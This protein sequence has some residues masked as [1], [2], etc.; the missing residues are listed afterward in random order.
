MAIASRSGEC[1]QLFDQWLSSRFEDEMLR[2]DIENQV[3]RFNLWASNHAIFAP[4]KASMDWR[5]RSAPLLES[6]MVEML[7]DLHATLIKQLALQHH[8]TELQDGTIV[9]ALGEALD[10]LF[11]L[12]RAIRRSGIMRRFVKV[13]N[14]VEY[15]EEG[16]NLTAAFREGTERIIAFR[17]RTSRASPELRQR[18]VDTI[19]LRQQHF[20]YLRAKSSRNGPVRRNG[21]P[22]IS[23]GKS[24]LSATF[25]VTGS[26]SSKPRRRTVRSAAHMPKTGPSIM[27]ATTAQPSR[28]P[29]AYS[30]KSANDQR[31]NVID[32]NDADLPLPPKI[33]PNLKESA[34][35]YCFLA[36]F[37]EE[38]SGERWKRHITQDLMPYICIQEPCLTPMLLFESAKDWLNHMK[39]QHTASGWICLDNT[40]GGTLFFGS[41]HGFKDHMHQSHRDQFDDDDLDDIAAACHQQLPDDI[42]IKDC[43]LCPE[44][45]V[46]DMDASEMLNH[47]ASHLL[48]LAQISLA[49]HADGDES[50]SEWSG[51]KNI[52]SYRHSDSGKGRVGSLVGRLDTDFAEQSEE[53][54][55]DDSIEVE[56]SAPIEDVPD[57]NAEQLQALWEQIRQP[58]PDPQ[59]DPKLSSFVARL[60]NRTDSHESYKS[61]ILSSEDFDTSSDSEFGPNKIADA[62]KTKKESEDSN[63]E[64]LAQ[65]TTLNIGAE[66]TSSGNPDSGFAITTGGIKTGTCYIGYTLHKAPVDAY[67]Q[68][69]WRKAVKTRMSLGQD[70]LADLVRRMSKRTSIL[71]QYRSLSNYKR[72]HVDQLIEDLHQSKPQFQWSFVYVKEEQR[73]ASTKTFPKSYETTSMAVI[74][75]GT[76]VDNS[77]DTRIPSDSAAELKAETP[78]GDSSMTGP[79]EREHWLTKVFL[80]GGAKTRLPSIPDVRTECLGDPR[81]V[82]LQRRLEENGYIKILRLEMSPTSNVH[83]YLRGDDHRIRIVYEFVRTRSPTQI[84][85]LPLNC[86]EIFRFHEN[87]LCLCRPRRS[88]TELIEW[89]TLVFST[90][91]DAEAFVKIITALQESDL[92]TMP[93]G[94]IGERYHHGLSESG[95]EISEADEEDGQ[96]LQSDEALQEVGAGS[97]QQQAS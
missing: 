87:S 54:Q 91:E 58:A 39:K 15:D 47:V 95:S 77:Q 69:T 70:D 38:L 25:S 30:V 61:E 44:G 78:P 24:T 48:S 27:T 10:G 3:F 31:S 2:Q 43:P 17:L 51:S 63:L 84:F 86:L 49:G 81:N 60:E 45:Q 57:A 75:M 23:V 68:Q 7:D 88:E 96:D 71:D 92:K 20:A 76:F 14:Y 55:D 90:I 33:A 6:T 53:D 59:S 79:E 41:E 64:A 37:K 74:F 16:V 5:L 42:A 34:C 12:S 46:V 80:N 67:S 32:L 13:E 83:F 52:P 85:C 21:Q 22:Q 94:A 73:D 82:K 97:G 8:D 28:M 66:E 65:Q 56:L 40:H 36:C 9:Q 18:I 93:P 50:R 72:H 11:R 62:S 4:N 35:P 1:A 19:C 26:L 29:R 89:S